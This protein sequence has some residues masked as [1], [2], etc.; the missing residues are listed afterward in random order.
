M[1]S[2][3]GVGMLNWESHPDVIKA[4]SLAEFYH[5]PE[6]YRHVER[7]ARNVMYNPFIDKEYK[8]ECVCL[9]YMHDLMEDT[10]YDNIPFF[11]TD[12][13]YME[14]HEF[15]RALCLLTKPEEMDYNR[16]LGNISALNDVPH[17]C[18]WWVKLADIKDHLQEKETLTEKLKNKYLEALPYLL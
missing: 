3:R 9:A 10:V 17:K 18:A 1:Q 15:H 8:L 5:T 2:E 12:F 11:E 16:Y 14:P 7:V 13:G 4:K 6:T